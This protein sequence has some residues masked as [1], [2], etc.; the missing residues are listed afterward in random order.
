MN[1][2]EHSPAP[3][4]EYIKRHGLSQK[5][6]AK[7]MGVSQSAVSQWLSNKKCISLVT[8][9]QLEKRTRS[10]IK[11]RTLFPKLFA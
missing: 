3:L 5:D 1:G 10:E 2:Y 7:A 11:V 6:F 4:A 9:Q 8:A